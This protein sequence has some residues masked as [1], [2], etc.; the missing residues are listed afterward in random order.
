MTN[1][2][3]NANKDIEKLSFEE[4]VKELEGIVRRLESGG[5]NLEK[6]IEDYTR[7]NE[8]KKHCEAKLADAK[9]KVEKIISSKDGKI[10]TAPFDVEE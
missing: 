7:G 6:S 8:L 4:A 1:K 3:A 9:L 10:K 5:E 2:P